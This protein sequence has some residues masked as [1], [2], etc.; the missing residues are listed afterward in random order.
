MSSEGLV[1]P[2]SG[3][4][5]GPGDCSVSNVTQSGSFSVRSGKGE[6]LVVVEL[7]F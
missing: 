6:L 3:L 7:S 5:W 2:L 4:E 1:W